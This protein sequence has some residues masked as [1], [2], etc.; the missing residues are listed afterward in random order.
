MLPF[1]LFLALKYLQPKRSFASVIPIIT[2]IGVSLGVAI[3]MIVLAVMTGFGDVWK[4]KILSFKPHITVYHYTGYI[5]DVDTACDK[6]AA[7]EG[8]V[9]VC[10][11][12]TTPVM[13]RYRD[14]LDPITATVIGIDPSRGSILS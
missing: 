10:P 3:L 11:T 14:D 5:N 6:I 4:E 1:P 12:I 8:V 13:I 9:T 7:V 2:V